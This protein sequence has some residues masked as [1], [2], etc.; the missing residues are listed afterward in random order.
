[1]I[2]CPSSKVIAIKK[3]YPVYWKFFSKLSEPRN[4]FNGPLAILSECVLYGTIGIFL[5]H[6]HGMP[7]PSMIFYR[8]FFSVLLILSITLVIQSNR[9]FLGFKTDPIYLTGILSGPW[10]L[11]ACL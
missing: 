9:G 10:D 4:L 2:F 5:T 3:I 6:I 11:V 7:I 1:M 8:L